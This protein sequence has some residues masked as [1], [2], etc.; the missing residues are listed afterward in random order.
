[1]TFTED[2]FG[3]ASREALGDLYGIVRDLEGDVVEVGCWEGRSTVALAKACH[4]T[5]VHAVDTWRG[6]PGEISADLAAERDVY[7]TFLSNIAELTDGNVKAHRMSWRDYFAEIDRPVKFLHIDAEHTYTEVRDNL[8]A[9]LKVAVPG[10]VICG[11]DAHHP[12]VRDAVLSLFPDAN[13]LA[14]LWW[15]QT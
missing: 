13:L 3:A 10:A 12:P 14:T 4:P 5:I 8:E 7:A 6:S 9:G 2:W 1:M 11:D 15:V